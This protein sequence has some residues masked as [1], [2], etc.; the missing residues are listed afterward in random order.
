[1]TLRCGPADGAFEQK[2]TLPARFTSRGYVGSMPRS[3]F[4]GGAIRRL[5][6][7]LAALAAAVGVLGGPLVAGVALGEARQPSARGARILVVRDAAKMHLLNANGN[8]LTEEGRASGTLPGSARATLSFN[9]SVTTSNFTFHL[10]D[11]SITGRGKARLHSGNGRYESFGGSATIVSGTGRYGHI[12][13]AGG[14]Y[15]VIDRT[16]SNAEVQVIGKLHM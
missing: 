5:A 14:F 4:L 7:V 8:T 16:T 10:K 11:G 9:G 12:S 13:G 3:N 6:P 15:G 1:M 2:E